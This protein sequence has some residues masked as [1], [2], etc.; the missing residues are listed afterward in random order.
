M[1]LYRIHRMKDAARQQFR[2]APHTS[3]VSVVKPKDYEPGPT[4][5]AAT[6]YAAW[7]SLR[8]SG[9]PLVIGDLLEGEGA[10]RIFKYIGFE[11]ARWWTPEQPPGGTAGFACPSPQEA[12]A[13]S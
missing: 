8:T 1:S 6:P 9:E 7:E 10:L 13:E 3:G 11:E 5:E 2:W 12:P 4:V